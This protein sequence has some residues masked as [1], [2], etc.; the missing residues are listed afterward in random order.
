MG[1]LSNDC[2][3]RRNFTIQR[4][5]EEVVPNYEDSDAIEVTPDDGDELSCVVQRVLLTPTM[6]LNPQRHSLFRTKCTINGKVCMII[7]DSESSENM[8]SKKLV[9][10]LN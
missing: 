3:Q 2:P 8:V 6:D 5:E 10:L 7:I 4:C 9:Q 1:H